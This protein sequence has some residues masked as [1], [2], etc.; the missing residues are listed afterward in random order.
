MWALYAG[1]FFYLDRCIRGYPFMTRTKVMLA[2]WG[3][4]WVFYSLSHLSSLIGLY[5]S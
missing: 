5:S 4:Q 1:L 3:F 2:I